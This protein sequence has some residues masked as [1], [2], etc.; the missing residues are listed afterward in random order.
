[1]AK[2]SVD[3][4]DLL[5]NY[6]SSGSDDLDLLPGYKKDEPNFLD[7]ID[8]HQSGIQKLAEST[9]VQNVLGAGDA[10]HNDISNALNFFLRTK[11]PAVKSGEGLAYNLGNVGGHVAG[12]LGGGEALEGA[13]AAAEGLPLAGKAAQALAGGGKAGVARRAL[14]SALYGAAESPDDR[15]QGALISGAL[16]P[17]FDALGSLGSLPK[18]LPDFKAKEVM[19]KMFG[20]I[21]YSQHMKDI[22]SSIK[23]AYEGAKGRGSELFEKALSG[24]KDTKIKPEVS[25]YAKIPADNF[26]KY[27]IDLNDMHNKYL[28]NPTIANAHELQSQLGTE[29]RALNNIDSARNLDMAGRNTRKIYNK[30]RDALKSDIKNTLDSKKEGL[31]TAY[32]HAAHHWYENVS[33]FSASKKL[34]EIS[35]GKITTPGDLTTL[36]KNPEHGLSQ[37]ADLL[38][39]NTKN[40]IVYSALGKSGAKKSA[41]SLLSNFD[42]LDEKGLSNYITDELKSNMEG[43]SKHSDKFKMYKKAG[44]MGLGSLLGAGLGHASGLGPEAISGL[45]GS[46][47]GLKYIPDMHPAFN[48]KLAET[49]SKGMKRAKAAAIPELLEQNEDQ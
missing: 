27:D 42:R 32:D 47:M 2:N 46:G 24:S 5:P 33:P 31:G 3:E 39:D 43:L 18:H 36:F 26:E 8:P 37:I 15:T 13:R 45:I 49:L 16:S 48:E 35:K 29:I 40:K 28:R 41:D 25:D 22:A 34:S 9:P 19:K 6:K 38:G 23:S 14:G 20:D 17:A 21:P 10:L 1:M 4:M 30:S 44:K 11:I 12:F 7:E